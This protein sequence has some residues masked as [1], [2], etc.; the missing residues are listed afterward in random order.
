MHCGV[1]Y[2]KTERNKT[3]RGLKDEY[4]MF[5]RGHQLYYNFIRQHMSLFGC[6]PAEMAG[7][8]LKLGNDKWENPL[9]QSMKYHD[10]EIGNGRNKNKIW[11]M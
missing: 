10:G 9:M 7:I 8:N 4:S 6:T 2:T 11:K 3:Q 1:F 5:V